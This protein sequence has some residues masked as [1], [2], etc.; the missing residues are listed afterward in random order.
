MRFITE[1]RDERLARALADRIQAAVTR[2]MTAMEVCGTHTMAIARF[3]LKSLLPSDV[4]LISGPGCPVCV[5]AQADID[6]VLALGRE[7]GVMLATFGDLLRVPGSHTTLEAERARGADVRVVY[8]PLDAVALAGAHPGRR[9]VFCGVGFET[10][11]PGVALAVRE[12][13]RRG[14]TNFYIYCAHKTVPAALAA[15]AGDP[16]IAL[17]GLLCPGHVS[18]IIG[19]D[20][21]RPVAEDFH[22]PCVIAGFEPLDVLQAL[23][24]LVRQIAAGRAE[25]EVPYTRAVPP[26]GN[27]AARQV[28]YQV[29]EPADAA[30]RGLGVIPGSGLRLR[31]EYAAHDAAA[32]APSVETAPRD[33]GCA[34]GRILTGRLAPA[35]CP[36]FATACTPAHPLGPCMVSSEGACAA[37]YKYGR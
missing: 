1:F 4:R 31:A 37:A 19:R 35:D 34:C 24:L 13:A 7:P 33:T 8:S 3:G 28:L 30:W 18:V 32:W 22:I 16:E 11:A 26:A 6:R 27:P 9:V 2:P 17:D 36:R 12:A 23:L 20:A 10:T 14:I 21:Y 15:L 29:F 5:T 25:V